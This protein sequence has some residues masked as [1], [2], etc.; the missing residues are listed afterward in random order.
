LR[1]FRKRSVS[2]VTVRSDLGQL[3]R[4]GLVAR[5]AAARALQQGQSELGFDLR[6]RLEVEAKRAIARSAAEMVK[7]EAVAL[8]ASTTACCL[9]PRAV[10]SG[11]VVVTNGLLSRPRW[12]TRPG[13]RCLTGGVLR[14]CNVARRGP[15]TASRTTRINKGSSARG[16]SLPRGL[17]T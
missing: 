7:G 14:L 2:E 6:M 12:P 11:L 15:G 3:A 4:Q 1:N 10:S 5:S 9:A 8:D 13:S 16:L 17:R